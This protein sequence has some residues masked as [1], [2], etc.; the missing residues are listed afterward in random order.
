MTAKN[1]V[2]HRDGI[3]FQGPR[4]IAPTLM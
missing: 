2:V 1:R 4:Y 3:H